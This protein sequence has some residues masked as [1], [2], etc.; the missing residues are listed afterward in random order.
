MLH[1]V[2]VL[3]LAFSSD[4]LLLASGCKD[5]HIKVGMVWM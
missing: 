5:G 1:E 3:A 2:A 4:T